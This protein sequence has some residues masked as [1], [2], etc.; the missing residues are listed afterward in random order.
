MSNIKKDD[1]DK[2]F[3]TGPIPEAWLKY[4]KDH[5][6]NPVAIVIEIMKSQEIAINLA[7]GDDAHKPPDN[8]SFQI[9]PGTLS[10]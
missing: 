3:K 10:K 2:R 5:L 1:P 9:A 6:N 4:F 7:R 8:K